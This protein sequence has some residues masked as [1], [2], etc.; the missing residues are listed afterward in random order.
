MSLKYTVI[1]FENKKS[2]AEGVKKEIGEYLKNLGYKSHIKIEADDSN[3]TKLMENEDIDLILMDQNLNKAKRGDRLIKQIRKNELYTEAILYSQFPKYKQK[4]AKQL[5]GVFFTLRKDLLQKT[6]RIIDLT[7]KKNLHIDN[8]RGLFIAEAIYTTSQI[9]EVVTRILDVS[10][11]TLDFFTCQIMQTGFLS[12]EAKYV[13]V[14]RFLKFKLDLLEKELQ[15]AKGKKKANLESLKTRLDDIK[16][17]FSKYQKVINIRNELAH[18]KKCTT[19]KNTLF[20][21]GNHGDVK[22]KTY[23]EERCKG[24]R[25]TF[26]DNSKCLKDLLKL[27]NSIK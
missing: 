15:S 16:D 27:V 5:D 24:I 6:K 22:E 10:G 13:F 3:L 7:L 12:D 14:Q 25:E 8:I 19:K 9:E 17:R 4:L 20:V 21:K 18:A 11:E 2:Y 23:D 1:L 26:L